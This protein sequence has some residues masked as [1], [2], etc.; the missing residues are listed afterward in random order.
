MTLL[1]YLLVDL[2]GTLLPV[3]LSFFFERY[4]NE[5]T[6]HFIS[7]TEP[8]LFIK[9][10]L[11]STQFMVE[12]TDP[13]LTNEDAFWS[14]FPPRL[15][16]TRNDL[17]P[18]FN[19]FYSEEFPKLRQY[20]NETDKAVRLLQMAT[21]LGLQIILATNPIFPEFVLK[22]RLSWVNCEQMPIK[23]ITSL[24]SMHFCKPNPLYFQ[25]ILDRLAIPA[26]ECL[27][28]GNDMEE[29]LPAS[30][31]GI[32]TYLVTDFLIDRKTGQFTP[33]HRGTMEELIAE[34][35]AIVDESKKK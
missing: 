23:W 12:N 25:E 29:D 3:D 18:I 32:E 21:D 14:D 9:G 26:D 19:R 27:M 8:R 1:R 5:L 6:P 4:L 13:E 15:E 17:E 35:P 20:V 24:E 33:D 2:D 34:L 30:R 22:E 10:I 31:V 28:V 16:K 11:G 7:I